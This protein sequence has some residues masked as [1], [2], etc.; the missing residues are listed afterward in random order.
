MINPQSYTLKQA[1]EPYTPVE[2]VM[3]MDASR[4]GYVVP[5]VPDDGDGYYHLLTFDHDYILIDVWCKGFE[6]VEAARA[7]LLWVLWASRMTFKTSCITDAISEVMYDAER[8]LST[9]T[10]SD[11]I[12]PA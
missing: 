6:T 1:Y 8:G 10:Q 4:N 5:S 12:F 3:L 11:E 2:R 9:P 7:A